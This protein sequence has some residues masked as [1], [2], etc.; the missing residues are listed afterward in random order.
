MRFAH[1]MADFNR[2]NLVA[3]Q[4]LEMVDTWVEKNQNNIRKKYIDQGRQRT[5]GEIIREHNSSFLR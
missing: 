3:L 5:E 1:R 2:A 4:H